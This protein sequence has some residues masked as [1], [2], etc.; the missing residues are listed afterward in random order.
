MAEPALARPGDLDRH[1][2]LSRGMARTLGIRFSDV[3][4]DGRL[5]THEFTD[6]VNTCRGCAMSDRCVGWMARAEAVGEP[7]PGFCEI[8]GILNRLGRNRPR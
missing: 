5:S 3:M 7:A 1:F 4:R 6:L 2:W 8:R